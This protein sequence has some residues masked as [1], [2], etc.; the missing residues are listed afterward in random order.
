MST[1]PTGMIDLHNHIVYGVDDGAANIDESLDIARQFAAEGV[2]TVVATPHFDGEKPCKLAL[3]MLR[4][5]VD[6]LRE[7]IAANNIGID[8]FCGNEV[9]LTP[10]L[11]TLLEQGAVACL[12]T[13]RAILIEVSLMSEKMPLF[14]ED[15]VFRLQ[16]AGYQIVLG[17][18]ERYG[19][20]QRDPSSLD[21]LVE[22]GVAL[23]LTAPALLGE[24]GSAIRRTAEKLLRRGLYQMAASDRHHPGAN[25]SLVATHE[26][27]G[28]L[29]G[30]DQADLLLKEN[31]ARL[32]AGQ[33]LREARALSEATTPSFF[34]RLLRRS[35]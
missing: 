21:A 23:Q 5:R 30:G 16:L 14:L 9:Y 3:R 7:A 29:A 6:E 12:G 28:E 15:T 18:P 4:E 27:I 11:P 35:G 2:T 34:H 20:V 8:L 19:F 13:T 33:T 10:S 25:R 17:H 26:R 1:Q 31:P 24:Y 22:R 32:L